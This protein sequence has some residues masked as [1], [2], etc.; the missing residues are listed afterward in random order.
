MIREYYMFSQFGEERNPKSRSENKM[1]NF[2]FCSSFFYGLLTWQ[3]KIL[4]F[5][6]PYHFIQI[7]KCVDLIYTHGCG[8]EQTREVTWK[9][10]PAFLTT[11]FW[12]V[13]QPSPAT[14]HWCV[15][16][17]SDTNFLNSGKCCHHN[18]SFFNRLKAYL[19]ESCEFKLAF[20]LVP[21]EH[22]KC[23]V[24]GQDC[25]VSSACTL[26]MITCIGKSQVLECPA[27]HMHYFPRTPTFLTLLLLFQLVLISLCS[28]N[29]ERRVGLFLVNLFRGFCW[30][31][32]H[33]QEHC[34]LP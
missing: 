14:S 17:C 6:I 21:A 5:H 29:L 23:S 15:L 8:P 22:L 25:R 30:S 26:L 19:T 34:L 3:Q 33:G 20:V 11:Y 32:N 1:K 27:F 7:K 10:S 9:I 2:S 13:I 12:I 31:T 24:K 28:S 16:L 4:F 18:F